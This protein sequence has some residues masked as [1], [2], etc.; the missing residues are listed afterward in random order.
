VNKRDLDSVVTE[1]F[2]GDNLTTITINKASV[3]TGTFTNTKL[4]TTTRSNGRERSGE[5]CKWDDGDQKRYTSTERKDQPA[6]SL[7]SSGNSSDSAGS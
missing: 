5:T 1:T 3:E 7:V 6:V 4:G 2:L